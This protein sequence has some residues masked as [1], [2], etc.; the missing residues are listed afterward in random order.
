MKGL[1]ERQREIL[2]FIE[3][4]IRIKGFSPTY[5][6]I[7]NHF[8]LSSLGTIYKHLAALKKKGLITAEKGHK[9]SIMT[10][11]NKEQ[12]ECGIS[13]PLIGKI[14]AGVPLEIFSQSTPFS[15]P[16]DFVRFPEKTYVLQVI[17][18]SLTE[19]FVCDNDF[20]IVEACQD[21]P[22]GSTIIALINRHDT[23]VK[24][25]FLEGSYI[26]LKGNNP[27]H[28]PILLRPEDVQIQGIVVHLIRKF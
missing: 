3:E 9:S 22:I 16:K 14:S 28:K 6:E 13:L 20:L 26:Y 4:F 1:T 2:N 10:V 24:R 25:Y 5:K 19:E 11:K 12:N 7:K 17:G 18:D 15:I 8:A 23:I 21:P 27:H